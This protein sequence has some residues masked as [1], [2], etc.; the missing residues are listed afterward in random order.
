MT[1][2]D[3]VHVIRFLKASNH[4]LLRLMGGEPTFIPGSRILC[5][6]D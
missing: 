3:A 5:G 1:G 4:R 2:D 6:S